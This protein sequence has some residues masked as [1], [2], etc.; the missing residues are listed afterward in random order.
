MVAYFGLLQ[1]FTLSLEFDTV[2][3]DQNKPTPLTF[4]KNALL[5]NTKITEVRDC[6]RPTA[7]PYE[8]RPSPNPI[9]RL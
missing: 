2:R 4:L 6:K 8:K 7:V 3:D 1:Y 5:P 9:R